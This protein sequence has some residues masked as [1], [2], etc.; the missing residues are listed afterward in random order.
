MNEHSPESADGFDLDR[1]KAEIR[2]SLAGRP[3]EPARPGTAGGFDAELLAAG[4]RRVEKHADI[5][6][7]VP[8][9]PRFRG[10]LR[11]VARLLAGVVLYLSRFLTSRQRECNYAV[12]NAL[13]NLDR[14]LSRLEQEQERQLRRLRADLERLEQRLDEEGRKAA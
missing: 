13:R 5:A 14:G 7:G 11:V 4:L 8:E 1:L 12:L 3:A 6:A 2:A 10:P 9:L